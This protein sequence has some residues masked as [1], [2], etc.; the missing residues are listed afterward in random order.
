MQPL[1]GVGGG[2]GGRWVEGVRDGKHQ[3]VVT[4]KTS[5]PS[6]VF[7]KDSHELLVFVAKRIHHQ[8]MEE[9]KEALIH[10][11]AGSIAN[12]SRPST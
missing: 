6:L 7:T 5:V 11:F 9:K 10:I 8:L 4:P 2:E 3:G 1:T 12:Q